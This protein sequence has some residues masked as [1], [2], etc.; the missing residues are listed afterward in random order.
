MEPADS[1]TPEPPPKPP[2]PVLWRNWITLIGLVHVAIGLVLLCTFWLFAALTPSAEENQYL[3]IVGFMI[4][5]GVLMTGLALCPVGILIKRWRLKHGPIREVSARKAIIFL[6][7]TFFVIMPVLGVAGYKGYHFTETAEFCGSCHEV[8]EPQ[9]VRYQ[10]SPHARATCAGCHV[11]PGAESFVKSKISGMRQ[12]YKVGTNSFPRPIPPAIADL[13][14]ARDTCETCHWPAQFFG[15]QLKRVV[16][17][18]HD[19][20]NTRTEYEAL[21]KVGGNNKFLARAEGIHSHMLDKV[22]YVATDERLETIPWV[23]YTYPDG[24]ATVFRSDGKASSDPPPAGHIRKLDCIDCHNL[25]GHEFQSPERAMDEALNA[26][27]L[28][29]TLPYIK[30]EAVK[31]L[32]GSYTTKDEAKAKIAEQLRTFYQTQGDVM[33]KRKAAVDQAISA[34]QAVYTMHFYTEMKTD[35]RTYPS[36]IGHLESPGCFRC[37]DNLHVAEGTKTISMECSS[38]HTFLYRDPQQ[39]NSITERTFVHPMKIH[40][41]WEGL[42]PH[43]K[44]LCTDCHDGGLGALGWGDAKSA[45]A[46]GDCHSS[47]RWLKQKAAREQREAA[48]RPA[49]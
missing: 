32:A 1:A 40:E 23:R 31:A 42:G 7:L 20:D 43:E 38:C 47:G 26:K 12:V 49:K 27:K 29:A 6:A 17:Y 37:H 28:D 5:P 25:V 11:G 8:M 18:A 48:T 9:F 46:C 14:P 22:E 16:R 30:R 34:V 44:M 15:S 21:I 33:E 36:H 35:W 41:A 39:R 24:K 45:S 19:K 2:R 4:L 3:A 13:R 10:A